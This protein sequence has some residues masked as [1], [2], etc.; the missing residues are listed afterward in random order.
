MGLITKEVEV[1]CNG[2]T[3]QHYESKG[4]VFPRAKVY[5]EIL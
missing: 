1:S 2:M 5:I 4:Y 3:L